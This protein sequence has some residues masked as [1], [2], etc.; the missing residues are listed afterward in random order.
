MAGA[1]SLILRPIAVKS[2]RRF[3]Q[4]RHYSGQ[5]LNSQW[6][7]VGSF[8]DERLIGCLS[9]GP[10]INRRL[11]NR[12]LEGASW[13]SIIEL[14][15]MAFIDETPRNVESRSLA[16]LCRLLRKRFPQLELLQTYADAT[17]CGDGA[18]Y[19]GAGFLLVGI[20]RNRTVMR[21][22]ESGKLISNVRLERNAQLGRG[23]SRRHAR[24]GDESAKAIAE[25]M[26][27]EP[28]PGFQLRYVKPLREGVKERLT[29]PIFEYA[30]IHRRGAGMYRSRRKDP[31]G[32]PA[33]PGGKGRGRTDPGAPMTGAGEHADESG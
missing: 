32:P 30:E 16:I 25:D 21:H 5:A 9:L 2:G 29:C 7:Y 33:N 12:I 8:L 4:R 17:Q 31:S 26:G 23:H 28:L 14:G 22:R 15:R 24:R 18:S 6:L 10:P 1:K 11:A 13:A 20:N 3:I 19:R 27:F